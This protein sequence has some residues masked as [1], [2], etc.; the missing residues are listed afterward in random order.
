MQQS[1]HHYCIQ[2]GNGLN[3]GPNI[4]A[5]CLWVTPSQCHRQSRIIGRIQ[6]HKRQRPQIMKK[7]RRRRKVIM[8]HHHLPCFNRYL[9]R[10]SKISS[11]AFIFGG[12]RCIT[13]SRWPARPITICPAQYASSTETFRGQQNATRDMRVTPNVRIVRK[14]RDK[15]LT[16]LPSPLEIDDAKGSTVLRTARRDGFFVVTSRRKRRRF[17][18]CYEEARTR[19]SV[20]LKAGILL[21]LP[22]II[23]RQV[24]SSRFV[25]YLVTRWRRCDDSF[26]RRRCRMGS[27]QYGFS[28]E[29]VLKP[30]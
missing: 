17:L 16:I 21:P 22:R 11:K 2:L 23:R 25:S 14:M 4:F 19:S 1:T 6:S 24:D 15:G 27:H 28:T 30:C 8:L 26:R 5:N 9:C 18:R 7:L 10:Y 20:L 12:S 13:P 29:P 3:H